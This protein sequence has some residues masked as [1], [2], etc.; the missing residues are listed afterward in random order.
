MKIWNLPK[1]RKLDLPHLGVYDPISVSSV[2]GSC[3]HTRPIT[4]Q[5][6]GKSSRSSESSNKLGDIGSICG[7][8]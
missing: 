3:Y 8:S 7:S 6:I 1:I 5:E 2:G 4:T